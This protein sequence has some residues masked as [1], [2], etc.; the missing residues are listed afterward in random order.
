MKES[1]VKK[2]SGINLILKKLQFYT[3]IG[4][5][6]YLS[7][8]PNPDKVV[9]TTHDKVCHFIGYTVLFLSISL[10]YDFRKKQFFKFFVLFLYSVIIEIIQ[11]YIPNR[12]FSYLDMVA[13]AT[14]LMFGWILVTVYTH[15]FAR[16]IKYNKSTVFEIDNK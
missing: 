12:S 10:W 13:N 5:L 4:L 16:N 14:G 7:V 1:I 9:E 8:T 11:Y 6:T 15:I 3:I 2:W